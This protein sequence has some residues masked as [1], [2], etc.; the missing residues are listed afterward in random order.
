M[1][2]REPEQLRSNATSRQAAPDP[3]A[4]PWMTFGQMLRAFE[5]VREQLGETQYLEEMERAGV[6]SPR[7][8]RSA[9]MALECYRSLTRLAVPEVA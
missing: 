2:D 7:Q 5:R 3:A 4:K 6:R 9:A 1:R 8:F